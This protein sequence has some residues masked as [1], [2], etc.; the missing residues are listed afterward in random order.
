[1]RPGLRQRRQPRQGSTGHRSKAGLAEGLESAERRRNHLGGWLCWRVGAL[2][3]DTV[4]TL[5]LVAQIVHQPLFAEVAVYGDCEL[6]PGSRWHGDTDGHLVRE[7]LHN[8]NDQL[9]FQRLVASDTGSC[10][11]SVDAGNG[12]EHVALTKLVVQDSSVR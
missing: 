8:P 5:A 6:I 2:T 11:E 10:D 3:R 1:M 9:I 4:Q 12:G 7:Q